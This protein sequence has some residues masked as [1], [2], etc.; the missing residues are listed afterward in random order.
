MIKANDV[1][2]IDKDI[3]LSLKQE[4]IKALKD[5]DFVSL[6]NSLELDEDV[7]MKYTSRLKDCVSE[8]K[9]CNGCQGLIECK[10]KARGFILTPRKNNNMI[11]F[12]YMACEYTKKE[13][14]KDN[15]VLFDI[16]KEIKNA[17]LSNVFRDDVNR[18]EILKKIMSYYNNYFTDN[19]DK[20]IYL[21]GSFG[22]GKTYLISALLN[23][24]AKKGVKSTV[25]HVPE[26]IRGLKESFSSDYRDRFATLK[27]TP[28]LLLD[29]I[30]AEY[31]TAWSRDEV[32][33]PL[34]HYRMNENLPTFFTSNL[35]LEQLEK[36][37]VLTNT[38]I[39]M[40][41]AQRILERIKKLSVPVELI[42]KNIR[43]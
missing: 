43:G 4:F 6:V 41:N 23:E 20:G 7:L 8:C 33:E 35:S 14:Y 3:E 1:F 2:K 37:F 22:T 18:V 19:K 40:I 30:G 34:L 42:S 11:N 36:H 31:L 12:S 17:S 9:N 16:S 27:T 13:E 26:L 29:D 38:S 39:D 5:K 21:Y 28:I 24:L 10:N 32:L 15:V 25:V